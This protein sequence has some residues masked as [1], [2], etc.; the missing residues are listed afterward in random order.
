MAKRKGGAMK[1]VY[2]T[3]LSM[4]I[5][6]L[7]GLDCSTE[8][9]S[10]GLLIEPP[11]PQLNTELHTEAGYYEVFGSRFGIEK[12]WRFLSYNRLDS[13]FDIAGVFRLVWKNS[14]NKSVV[15]T[16]GHL[17]FRDKY[18]LQIA[19]CPVVGYGDTPNGLSDK[20]D[21]IREA[22]NWRLKSQ[23]MVEANQTRQKDG[24]FTIHVDSIEIANSIV[25]MSVSASF[26]QKD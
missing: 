16:Q 19:R 13:G 1:N 20:Y 7:M 25:R 14:T 26:E 6:S 4:V 3:V 24:N 8:K 9:P 11:T 10:Q 21:A 15:V 2:A 5:A 23:L 18:D 17:I 12:T 22:L